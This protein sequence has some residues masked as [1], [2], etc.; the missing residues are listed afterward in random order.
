[1]V[2]GSTVVQEAI[3][4]LLDGTDL[5]RDRAR[6]TMD[7]VMD[8]EA[9][10]A[11]IAG[12]LVALRAKGETAEEIA[13]FAEAMRS[14]VV[15]VTPRRSPI[16]DVVGTGGDG[17]GTFNIS[18]AAAIVAAASGAAVA[19]HGNRSASSQSGSADVLEALGIAID[20][21]PAAIAESIDRLGFGFMFARLHHP[22]MGHAAPVRVEL[23]TRT[24]FNILGPLC[25]PAG[26]C[27][28]LF[29]VHSPGLAMVYAEALAGLGATRAIVVHGHG[30]ID[31]LSPTG[32]NMVVEVVDG[33]VSEGTVDPAELGFP[34]AP[35]G[36]LAG[37]SPSDNASTI[38]GVLAGRKGP[39]RD[40]V[41]LNAAAA[42]VTAGVVDDLPAGV[43]LATDTIDRGEAARRLDDLVAFTPERRW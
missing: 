4:A 17:M 38:R 9:T 32:P 20:L 34:P 7:A 35:P 6:L 25:N 3:G 21:P 41:V 1:M 12:F 43:S 24:V 13:G 30:G 27:N 22:A 29:G 31:E 14:R 23:G 28:G 39:H 40:A 2:S 16:I 37:G 33:A 5:S 11:Q 36:S 26:A 18:T 10:E 19:K 8:G 42:L 15:A